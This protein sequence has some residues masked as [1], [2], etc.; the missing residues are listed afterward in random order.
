VEVVDDM[1]LTGDAKDF[2]NI[3]NKDKFRAGSTYGPHKWPGNLLR[4]YVPPG[5]DPKPIESAL[6]DLSRVTNN[7]V[8]FQRLPSPSGDYVEIYNAGPGIC[9][10]YLGH[11]GG[12]QLLSLGQNCWGKETI[13]HEFMHALGFYHEHER[14][15]RDQHVHIDWPYVN[16]NYCHAY[17]IC[18]NCRTY[19]QYN[20]LS[21]MHYQSNGFGCRADRPH[22]MLN[23]K[24]MG[25]INRNLQVTSTDIYNIKMHYGCPV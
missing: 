1:I 12:R 24:T 14:P 16:T 13:T 9:H 21:I 6:A 8:R 7:C 20:M 19:T 17:K 25:S 15:D 3:K 11:Q 2:F 18:Q 23:R 10:A 22:V 4:Y 5:Y